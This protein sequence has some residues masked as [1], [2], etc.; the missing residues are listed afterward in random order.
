MEEY[1]GIPFIFKAGG[2]LGILLGAAAGFTNGALA[3]YIISNY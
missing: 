1:V 2:S 3:V